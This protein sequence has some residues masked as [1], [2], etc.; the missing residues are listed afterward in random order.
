M[1]VTG[2]PGFIGRHLVNALLQE[3]HRVRLLARPR[4]DLSLFPFPVS[5]A[6][7]GVEVFWGQ[8]TDASVVEAAARGV[9][10]VFH[11]AACA[12]PWARDPREFTAVNVEGTRLVCDAAL[13][14]GVRRLVHV[15]TE[16]V[17]DA[18][19]DR[20]A[21]QRTKRAAEALVAALEGVR[22][23]RREIAP[24]MRLFLQRAEHV[25]RSVLIML[26]LVPILTS[27]LASGDAAVMT[28]FTGTRCTILVKLPVALSGGKRLN[29]APLAGAKLSMR[30]LSG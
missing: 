16:L 12:R 2:G 6:A 15:S 7:E 9:D 28:I 14:L 5:P 25:T 26:L 3:G 10:T 30:P 8:V 20:T 27:R 4:S 24:P 19:P 18:T 23:A 29:W 22:A 21:Y 11:L 13:T 1:L 17:Q